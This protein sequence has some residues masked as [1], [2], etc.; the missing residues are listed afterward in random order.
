[1]LSSIAYTNTVRPDIVDSF[2][3]IAIVVD[4]L[5]TAAVA[6]TVLLISSCSDLASVSAVMVPLF[7]LAGCWAD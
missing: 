4:P 6:S 3:G 1:M 2:T 5:I 7:V